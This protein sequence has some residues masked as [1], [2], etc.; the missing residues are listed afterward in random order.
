MFLWI[1]Q[2]DRSEKKMGNFRLIKKQSKSIQN[3]SLLNIMSMCGQWPRTSLKLVYQIEEKKKR[4][5]WKKLCMELSTIN[6]VVIGMC[7]RIF[8]F[9]INDHQALKRG[10]RMK[11]DKFNEMTITKKTKPVL[12]LN[13]YVIN[14]LVD[15]TVKLTAIFKMEKREWM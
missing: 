1:L 12:I 15:I 6:E 11:W 9:F 13:I 2:I 3:R 5:E 8:F 14:Q 10:I 7:V 4:E